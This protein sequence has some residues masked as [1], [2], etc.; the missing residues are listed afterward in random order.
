M[1]VIILAFVVLVGIMTCNQSKVDK[2]HEET[3][4]LEIQF[5]IDSLKHIKQDTVPTYQI[6]PRLMLDYPQETK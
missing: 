4:K 5:K 3:K 1:G 6:T 2:V